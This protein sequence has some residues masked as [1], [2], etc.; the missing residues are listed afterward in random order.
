[1]SIRLLGFGELAR[2][3]WPA[4]VGPVSKN[5]C[6]SMKRLGARLR[7]VRSSGSG[8]P[9]SMSARKMCGTNGWPPS[10]AKLAMEPG[11]TWL[12]PKRKAAT[13]NSTGMKGARRQR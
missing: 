6:Q 11:Q 5:V 3:S 4:G 7:P 2:A 9:W 10:P 8:S 1:M 12:C 13:E